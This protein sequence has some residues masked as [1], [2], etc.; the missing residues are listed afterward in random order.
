MCAQFLCR[1]SFDFN[2][3]L[4]RDGLLEAERFEDYRRL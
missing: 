1:V 2:S 3:L 4:D